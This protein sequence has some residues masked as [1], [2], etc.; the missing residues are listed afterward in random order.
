MS[1]EK[2]VVEVK[3]ELKSE[4]E[5]DIEMIVTSKEEKKQKKTEKK[6]EEKSPPVK[7]I[8]EKVSK[9]NFKKELALKLICRCSNGVNVCLSLLPYLKKHLIKRLKRGNKNKIAH[10]NN[11]IRN[12]L[13]VKPV[14]SS[15][16]WGKN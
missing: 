3:V 15:M 13:S 10:Y 6:E 9:Q 11:F 12:N 1:E 4:K 8:H 16:S 5:D 14:Q 2:E 7:V